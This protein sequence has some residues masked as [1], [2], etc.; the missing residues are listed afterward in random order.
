MHDYSMDNLLLQH[1][2][3]HD[4]DE[5]SYRHP[6]MPVGKRA[7]LFLAFDALRGFDAAI[8]IACDTGT[9]QPKRHLDEGELD[10][11]NHTLSH[12]MDLFRAAKLHHRTITISVEYFVPLTDGEDIP[13]G[14]YEQISGDLNAISPEF[15]FLI[16]EETRIAFEDISDISLSTHKNRGNKSNLSPL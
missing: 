4:H 6:S 10:I 15:C 12:I 2:P 13:R 16:I 7:K 3:V 8:D 5:F 14:I 11:L 1:R 9:W